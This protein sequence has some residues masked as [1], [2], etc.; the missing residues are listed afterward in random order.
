MNG[1]EDRKPPPADELWEIWAEYLEQGHKVTIIAVYEDEEH[2]E[3]ARDVFYDNR[4]SGLDL[5]ADRYGVVCTCDLGWFSP[6]QETWDDAVWWGREHLTSNGM[7]PFHWFQV[8]YVLGA[9]TE[10]DA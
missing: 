8:L 5:P 10:V 9:E 2:L 7:D 3:L 6:R 4:A 1:A